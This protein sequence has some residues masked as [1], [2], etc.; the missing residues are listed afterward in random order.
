M[1]KVSIILLLICLSIIS[2]A[3]TN[4]YSKAVGDLNLLATWGDQTDGSGASPLNFVT[5]NQVFNIHNR[6]T[7]TVGAAWTVSGAGSK[8]IVGDGLGACAFTIPAAFAVT[9]T[10]DVEAM[11]TLELLHTTIPTM[12][13]L[14]ATSTVNYARLIGVQTIRSATYG[15]L[16][17]SNTSGTQTA[18]G[19]LTVN[20]HLTTTSG[21]TLNMGA[22]Q[23]L[24]DLTTITHNGILSTTT[25]ANPA[26][27]SGKDWSGGTVGTVVFARTTGG[28]FIPDGTYKTLT[29]N[30]T[31]GVNTAAT[32]DINVV[33][34]LTLAAGATLNMSTNTLSFATYVSAANS[35]IRTQNTSASPFPSGTSFPGVIQYNAA[36]GGQTVVAG[37]YHTL[38]ITNTSG[39]NTAGGNLEVNNLLTTSSA[40]ARLDMS[41]HLLSGTLTTITNSGTIG[42]ANTS[43][44]P[45]PTGRTWGGTIEYNGTGAQT[46][47]AGTFVNLALSGDKG[48]AAIT[49]E[50]GTISLSGNFNVTATNIGSY[51]TG[52]NTFIYTGNGANSVGGITY[53]NLTLTNT[54][55]VKTA[56]GAIVVNGA[57]TTTS[58]GTLSMNTF[59]LSGAMTSITHNGAIFTSSTANPA[60]PGGKDWSGGT[61][62]LVNFTNTTGGQFIPNGTFKTLTCSNTS[63]TNTVVGGNLTVTG[64]ITPSAAGGTLDMGAHSLSAGTVSMVATARIHTQSTSATALPSG[65]AWGVINYNAA[66][67]GQTI[68]EGTYA[69]LISDNTSGINTAGGD[70][71]VNTLLSVPNAGGT[72]DMSTFAVSGTLTTITNNGTITTANTSVAPFT[73]GRTYGGSG[74]IEY[75]LLTGGQ[76]V[77][78]GTY[79]NM[80]KLDNTSGTNAASGAITA[81]AGLITAA[82]GTFEMSTFALSGTL[83][84]L[85]NDGTIRTSNTSAAPV[86]TGKTW[87]G[88]VIYDLV[89]GGQTVMAG[90]YNNLILNNTSGISTASNDI[91]VNGTLTT[92]AGGTFS[93]NNAAYELLGAGMNVVNNG[94]ISSI[95]TVNPPFPA[96]KIWGG[97]IIFARTNGGQS[98]PLGTYND[99]S[100]LN[101]SG[102]NT[103]VGELTIDGALVTTSGGTLAMAT[104]QLLGGLSSITH[105]GAITSTST[106]S[107]AIPTGKD[108]SGGTTGLVTFARTAGGQFIPAGTYKTLT[109]A[110]TSGTNTVLGDLIVTG[111]FTTSATGGTID[112]VTNTFSAATISNNGT[113][114]T[115]NITANPLPSGLTWGGFVNYNAATGGQ[116]IVSG[117]YASLLSSNTSGTNTAGNDLTVNTLL[118]VPNA[119][120]ILD[121]STFA[122]SG[123]LTTITN[124]GTITTANTS[125]APFTLAKTYGGTGTVVYALTTGGQT[126]ATGTYN[127]MLQLSNTS[128]TNTAAG[129]IVLNLGLIT[130]AGGTFDMS[131]FALSGTLTTI[132]NDGT[133]RTSNISA[134]PV[135]T[136]KIWDGTGTFIYDLLTGGQT[137]MAGTYNNLTLNNTSGVNT[138]SN[139]ITVNGTLTTT[140]GGTFLFNNIAYEL[141]GAGMTVA[142]NGIISTICN[143]NPPLPAGKTWGGSVNFA[144]LSGAQSVPMGIYNNVSFLNTSGT[145]TAVGD[146]TINGALTT[147]SGGVVN[148]ATHQLSGALTSI[149]HNGT[150]NTASTA[151]P[152]L[153]TGKDWS[154]G[155]T[156]LITFNSLTGG[157]FIPDGTFKTLTC[158]NT[159]GTNTVL[160][161]IAI[162]GNFT[163]SAAGGTVDMVTHTMSAATISNNGTLLTQNTSANPLPSGLTWAG[164]VNYNA[165]TG[166]QTVVPGVY[167][168]LV[169]G[170][171]SG[172]NTAAGNLTV[173]TLLNII[174]PGATL[175][176]STFTLAGTLTTVTNNGVLSTSNT[177]ATPLT[178]GITWGGTGTVRYAVT[179][180]GQ[181]IRLG[182]Y[183]NNLELSNT[184]GTNTA[185]GVLTVNGTLTV[186]VGGTLNMVTFAIAG[187]GVPAVSGTIRTQSTTNPALPASKIWGGTIIYDGLAGG[188]NIPLGTYNN[189]TLSNTSG[190]QT[191]RGEMTVNGALVTTSGGVLVMG[192]NQLLGSIS[193]LTHNGSITTTCTLNPAIPVAKDWSGTGG[194]SLVSFARTTGEQFISGGTYKTL[195]A[196]NTSN[197]NNVVGGNLTVTGTM[198]SVPAGGTLD[199]G[200]NALAASVISNNGTL[201]T[202]NTS[203]NP[204]PSGKNWGGT[205]NYNGTGAQTM[206]T[207]TFVNLALSENRTGANVTLENGTISLSGNFNV[208]ATNVGTYNTGTNT[209]IYTGNT[210]NTVGGI[211]YNNLTLSNTS[212]TKTAGGAVTVNGTLTTANGG[213]FNMSTFPLTGALTSIVLNGTLTTNATANPAIPAGKTWTGTTGLVRFA[214]LTGGQFVPTGSYKALTCTH[215]SGVNTAVGNIAV[216][217][218]FITAA[219]GGTFDMGTNDLSANAIT[220]TNATLRTQSTSATPIPAAKT[221]AGT[222]IYDATTGGQTVV[223]ETS[224]LGL[225]FE[226]TS[227]TNTANG[228]IVV[229]GI[230]T[231]GT[232][233]S[234]FDLSTFTLSGT[235]TAIAGGGTIATQNTAA[236]PIKVAQ[237]WTQNI[238]YKRATGGQTIVNGTYNG[239]LTNSNTSGTNTVAAAANITVNGNL[240]LSALSNISDNNRTVTVNGN[241]AGTGTHT[242]VS[243]GNIAMTG[244]G[245]TISSVTLG[246]LNLNNAGGFGLTGNPQINGTLTLTTGRLTIANN[247]LTLGTAATVAGTPASANMIVTSGTG[248]VRKRYSG[249]GSF[250]FPVGDATPNFSPFTVNLTG[251]TPGGSAYIGLNVENSI[252]PE[253]A[254]TDDYLN[255]YWHVNVSDITAPEY[256]ITG[257]YVDGDIVGDESV[258]VT[259]SYAGTLPWVIE[260]TVNTAANTINAAGLDGINIDYTGFS[261]VPPTV[262]VTPTTSSYCSG[263]SSILT[264][265]GDG[266]PALTY[267]WSPSTGLSATTGATVTSSFTTGITPTEIVYTVTITD[268]NGITATAT[269]AVTANP[270]PAAI[271]FGPALCPTQ[272][273]TLTSASLGGVWSSHNPLVMSVNAATGE[274]TAVINNYSGVSYTTIYYTLP[275]GC[276]TSRL[277]SVNPLPAPIIGGY[278]PLCLGE[279][280]TLSCGTLGQ[281]WSSSNIG[282]AT[283]T[284]GGVVNTVSAG[285]TTISYTNAIGCAATKVVTVNGPLS[286][287]TGTLS[288]CTGQTTTLFNSTPGGT[289]SSSNNARAIVNLTTGVVS[290]INGGTVNISYRIGTTCFSVSQVT[291]NSN[292]AEIGGTKTACVGTTTTLTYPV[293]GGTWSSATPMIATVDVNTGLV[294]GVGI[295]TTEITYTIASGCL[296]TVIVTVTTLP[297]AITGTAILCQS[298]T[299]T[300]SSGSG[301]WSSS[302]TGIATVNSSGIVSGISAGNANITFYASGTG[303]YVTRE[304]T[305]NPTPV[306]ATAAVCPTQTATLTATPSGGTWSISNPSVATVNTITG[307]MTGVII[308]TTSISHGYVTNTLPTGCSKTVIVTVNPIPSA[309]TGGVRNICTGATTTLF[310]ATAGG[311]WSSTNGGVASVSPVG[312]VTGLGSG[313]S[314]ISYTNS[315]GCARTAEMTVSTLPVVAPITGVGTVCRLSTTSLASATLGGTWS[316]GNTIRATVDGSGVVTGINVGTVLITYTVGATGCNAF[317]TTLV[318]VNQIPPV[319]VIAGALNICE[320]ATSALTNV[321]LGGVWSSSVPAVGTVSAIGI[322]SAISTGNTTISYTVT[323]GFGCENRSTAVVTVNPSPVVAPLTGSLN[324]CKDA[325]STLSSITAGGVWASSTPSVATVDIAGVVTGIN[326]GTSIISYSVTNG[327]GCVT[328]VTG[329]VTVNPVP[330]VS[331]VSGIYTVCENAILGLNATLPLGTWTSSNTSVANI[332]INSGVVL[333]VAVGVSTMSYT[334]V[335]SGCTGTREVTVIQAPTAIGGVS[336]FCPGGTGTLTSSPGGGTWSSF[337]SGVVSVNSVTGDISAV[338]VGY[339]GMSHTAITYALPNGCSRVAYP[340]VNP[341][342][343]PIYGGIH[344]LCVGETTTLLS[345]SVGHTWSSDDVGIATVSG[346][347]MVTAVGTGIA[348]ISYTNALGCAN[349]KT[350]TVNAALSDNVGSASICTG[351]TTLYT[352]STSGGTWTSSNVSRATV[353]LTTGLVTGANAGT[354]ILSYRSPSGCYKTNIVTVNTTPT[355]ITGTRSVCIDA[356]TTLYSSPSGGEWS[357]SVPGIATIGSTSGIVSGISDGNSMV[358]YTAIG[359]CIRTA[360][361]T[362]NTLPAAISGTGVVCVG[363]YSPLTNVSGTWTSSNTGIVAVSYLGMINGISAGNATITFRNAN[364]CITTKVVTINPL[365]ATIV[366]PTDLCAGSTATLSTTPSGGTWTS[367]NTVVFTID[368]ISGDMTAILVNFFGNSTATVNYTLPTGCTRS[369]VVTINRQ[370]STIYGGTGILCTGSTTTQLSSAPDCVWSSGAPS[371]ATISPTG[372]VTG[373]SEGNAVISY[374]NAAGC[375]AKRVITVNTTPA[376]I[377]GASSVLVGQ[378]TTLENATVGGTW[379]SSSTSK[380]TIGSVSGIVTGIST[381]TSNIT[382]LMPTGCFVTR[383]MNVSAARSASEPPADVTVSDVSVYPNP[384][385]GI[386]SVATP[387]SGT[388]TVYTIDGREIL[389]QNVESGISNITLPKSIVAGFYTC[390]FTGKDGVS[391]IVRL[392]YESK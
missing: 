188:Q 71:T 274:M 23:L 299:S 356:T 130:T 263:G 147:T 135:T 313:T 312:L 58:G 163:T 369:A 218:T 104:N 240:T 359:G 268:G 183:N 133:I 308:N 197:T 161:N 306:I 213:T 371:I 379:S 262:T 319:G 280:T 174:N 339:A 102:I 220:N 389:K 345:G 167:T 53:N 366:T 276:A 184:S 227:G 54:S 22:N 87:G 142:N 106:L 89:T 152:A 351:T 110:N 317:V 323:N 139:D 148:M 279:S 224:Y 172:V 316:S 380:A 66:T 44:T 363:S 341:I 91:T 194:T 185:S 181:T 203:A 338:I 156:G 6:A 223:T 176:M 187:T 146:I 57:L 84:S 35:T 109:C 50:D 333:P 59:Q 61:T 246:N 7:A 301:T 186:P 162:T 68:A 225:T 90:T 107:P 307:E 326:V 298:S 254:S 368:P 37:T 15:N 256:A 382:Y 80:L 21:G 180:G 392:V 19:V 72:I 250:T 244:A 175:D 305:I 228:N 73:T 353:N 85:T 202:Q 149:V 127:N 360:E 286:D 285:T 315:F 271:S 322:V 42:T 38:T 374:T 291:V 390:L 13:V 33:T 264:A 12:G 259:T 229:N 242:S 295:G 112:M 143:V 140:A 182:T 155:T 136:G 137:V 79:N 349:T 329:I 178:S 134:A 170:N 217:N 391:T 126:I 324:V 96:G 47:V 52:A 60:L 362:V 193:S 150:I 355:A 195:T 378:T 101:T 334:V 281:T 168:R 93:F 28:Q 265:S 26:L 275:E 20:G 252:H 17:L 294:T 8:I 82:G 169:Q 141:L 237:T 86:T 309:I 29:L 381:G 343:A 70:L 158:T 386:F 94:T 383:S 34:T 31:S 74:I 16:T 98:V 384:T 234:V 282:V 289:W 64:T 311:V 238:E 209:F 327:F 164:F 2:Y 67:G 376:S 88:T 111:N 388:V 100:F 236:A 344:S 65:K 303:C 36:T 321:S 125:G 166:G 270:A 337:N 56:N 211:T 49:L 260:G 40:T 352:N 287:N 191:A 267:T 387:V 128:G 221:I 129:N 328:R 206:V 216:T 3:Q 99:V 77:M 261:G 200:T 204:L 354:T 199:M 144:R 97:N 4:F 14:N 5:D 325:T 257:T 81:N 45:I 62:G 226:N 219:A 48:G 245:G 108:W 385:T 248:E 283:I 288:V 1:K 207:G 296:R 165:A 370:P 55:A 314:T 253:N 41:T 118:S 365:P 190:S 330:V 123:T 361:V 11:A 358:T 375:S 122:M 113:L 124:N 192:V 30:N 177:S 239:G 318:T 232:G 25:T 24:G 160:G 292:V 335:S 9:G 92:T 364:N 272:T 83:T 342:P 32:G 377:T 114:S 340:T 116:T 310:S 332:T 27:P 103:A 214:N 119:G 171:T 320:N 120:G 198:T 290:G 153:P 205:V 357:S 117:T 247:N 266:N 189:L 151:N 348:T 95:C 43:A 196:T 39:A 208:T 145:N 154:G 278:A 255:R 367:S 350:I 115:Q 159:S 231:T 372:V 284:P 222:V 300:L 293:S 105:N 138:A 258:L 121:M 75:V 46:M 212:N 249:L 331:T 304:V 241:I 273:A 179:T 10:V 346:G 131:T 157:Q 173:N 277:V 243:A 132:T 201:L 18:G 76:T 373:V 210:A 347:G 230:L 69:T 63:N 297:A 78:S 51:V 215:T 235:L 251:G 336:T 302:N 269:T 233:T